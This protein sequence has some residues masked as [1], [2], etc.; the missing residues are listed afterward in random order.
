MRTI[1]RESVKLGH[2]RPVRV[3]PFSNHGGYPAHGHEFHEICLITGGTALHCSTDSE[4]L[5][6]KG[7][8][9]VI[10]PGQI[11]GFLQ[12]R[13]LC[14]VNSYYLAPWLL[15]EPMVSSEQRL[16]QL[17][18]GTLLFPEKQSAAAS[19]F[20]LSAS[21]C[22]SAVSLLGQIV[23]EYKAA[24]P[25]LFAI[26][27]LFLK[28]LHEL[29]RE[30]GEPSD[31]IFANARM[32]VITVIEEVERCVREN[33][34]FCVETIA[35]CVPC[36][37]GHLHRI[38]TQTCGASPMAYYQRRRMQHA[39]NLI[40]NSNTSMT[41][42]AHRIGC[43]DSAHFSRAFRKQTGMSPREYRAKHSL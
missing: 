41:E 4:R 32:E 42:I 19:V 23:A 27:L 26:K 22:N 37:T 31:G 7:S 6:H 40:L 1:S 12:P 2:F 15:S 39:A 29:S 17:F 30:V 20:E 13:N 11:H 25:S 34:A 8:V 16:V 14:G 43:A 3:H 24:V 18:L 9:I 36:S 33:S 35:R 28:F 21:T 38:F 5:L 10:A